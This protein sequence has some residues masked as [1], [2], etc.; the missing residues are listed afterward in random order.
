METPIAGIQVTLGIGCWM[1]FSIGMMV[2]NKLAIHAFPAE[3][4]L[5]A[6]QMASTVVAMLVFCWRSIRIGS[7]RD[8]AQWSLVVPFYTGLTLTSV[9]ALKYAPMS[10]VVVFRVL[11]PLASLMVER[12]YPEPMIVDKWTILSIGVMFAGAAMYS[13]VMETTSWRQI[14]WVLLNIFFAVCDRLLQRLMLARDQCPV[15]ISKTGVNLLNNL[16]GL[17]PLVVV[18]A[19][20]NEAAQISSIFHNL[21]PEGVV[22]V[23][24]SCIFGIGISY[25]GVWAQTMISATS[26]LVLVNANKFVVILIEVLYMRAH[27]LQPVQI[28]GAVITIVGGVCYGKARQRLEYTSMGQK[29]L[30]TEATHLVGKKV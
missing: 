17:I 8:A 5:V 9:L 2:F 16:E 14:G 15:D 20:K 25:T 23:A 26:F 27:V 11:A 30:A 18:A 28:A 1:L 13:V 21:T 24:L 12:F 7:W 6:F 19:I 10:L 29:Q 4:T 3:C 22:W